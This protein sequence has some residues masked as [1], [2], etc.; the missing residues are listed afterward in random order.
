MD[1][2]QKKTNGGK[3]M[4]KKANILLA[5]GVLAL[6]IGVLLNIIRDP[7]VWGTGI[8][9]LLFTALLFRLDPLKASPKDK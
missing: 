2:I 5:V 4:N 1:L 8:V 6:I 3:V 7:L 9:I